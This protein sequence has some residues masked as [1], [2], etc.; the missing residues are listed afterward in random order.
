MPEAKKARISLHVRIDDGLWS[1]DINVQNDF[2]LNADVEV[3]SA[4]SA[5]NVFGDIAECIIHQ[6]IIE[7]KTKLYLAEEEENE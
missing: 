3:A 4:M 6:A 5:G 7:Y 2:E 1:S